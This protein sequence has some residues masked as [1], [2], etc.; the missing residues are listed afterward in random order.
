MNNLFKLSKSSNC[1]I[2]KFSNCVFFFFFVPA[3]L[4]DQRR[5]NWKSEKNINNDHMNNLFQ[6]EKIFEFSNFRIFKSF[7][8]II[9][10]SDNQII[11]PSDHLNNW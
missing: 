3:D 8:Q 9:G 7:N 10:S 2:V 1:Q 4:A 11:R 5:I 6:T